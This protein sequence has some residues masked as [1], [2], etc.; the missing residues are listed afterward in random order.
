VDRA[1]SSRSSCADGASGGGCRH[2]TY[3]A[4]V[5]VVAGTIF[6]LCRMARKQGFGGES[7]TGRPCSST[8][9]ASSKEFVL[10][11][12]R[13]VV[14]LVVTAGFFVSTSSM[15]SQRERFG[16]SAHQPR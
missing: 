2:G 14:G 8:A 12:M 15:P 16:V 7:V 3:A 10:I 6:L 5:T 9:N 1:A 13:A 11:I 4:H